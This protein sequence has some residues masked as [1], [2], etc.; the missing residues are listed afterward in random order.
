ML[1]AAF[2]QVR[3]RR[4]RS[5]HFVALKSDGTPGLKTFCRKDSGDRVEAQAGK[6][7]SD[8]PCLA[9]LQS[10]AK[11]HKDCRAFAREVGLSEENARALADEL[12]KLTHTKTTQQKPAHSV[13]T[14][15]G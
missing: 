13:D 11:M 4:G 12:L 2:W 5:W 6:E 1:K 8:P 10:L 3:L 14:V 7:I 9:C 15:G